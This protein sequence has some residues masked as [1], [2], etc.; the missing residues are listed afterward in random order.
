MKLVIGNLTFIML[1]AINASRAVNE[2]AG[3]GRV[4]DNLI[5]N[6]LN[7]PAGEAG[8][9]HQ[10]Q[11]LL[12][13]NFFRHRAEKTAAAMSFKQKN[14]QIRI[15]HWPGRLQEWWFEL[16]IPKNLPT[17]VYLAPTFLDVSLGL[18]IPQ[19]VIIHDLT[20]FI[21]PRHAGV[22]IS[23]RYQDKTRKAC[24]KAAKIIAVSESTKK[25]IVRLLKIQ[26]D[27]IDVIYPGQ[28]TFPVGGKLPPKI[29]PKNYILFVGTIEPR[30]NL[31]NL[32]TA[33]SLLPTAIRNNYPLVIVGG[34]GWNNN[35]E[36]AEIGK[37]P[38][39][40]WL[41]YVSNQELGA[42]YR[43]ASVF[44]YPSL[45]EGFGLPVL[46]AQ[47]FGVP[48]VTSNVSS[49]PEAAGE[50]ALLIDP[51]NPKSISRALQR[52]LEDKELHQK[53]SK[54]ARSHAQKFSWEK[55]ARETLEVFKSVR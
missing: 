12:L 42:L 19:V 8:I 26:P 21:Y 6:L 49:L 39:V 31:K 45:Y 37:T 40:N 13:F 35:I 5:R 10:N 7:L 9:D 52:V 25:D 22:E 53:L 48:V 3:V 20:N 30:K 41:G 43:N 15:S 36:L 46:E 16:D 38:G 18:Q 24:A 33:Y 32:L 27:K 17:D 4:A 44:A 2:K 14:S 34:K 11:Y 55:A 1:I 28:T 47:Q 51:K 50:G 23:R 54:K 29:K